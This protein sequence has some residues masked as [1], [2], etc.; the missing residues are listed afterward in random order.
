MPYKIIAKDFK[1]RA[2]ARQWIILNQLGRRNLTQEKFAYMLGKLYEEKK[3]NVIENLKSSK[4]PKPQ[5]EVLGNTAKSIADEYKI[6]HAT[7]ERAAT[8][9]KAV[10]ILAKNLGE[11]VKTKILN[12]DIDVTRQEVVQLAQLNPRGQ[13]TVF[14][15]LVQDNGRTQRVPTEVVLAH[16]THNSGNNEWYT[17]VEYIKA[18]REVMKVIDLDPASNLKANETVKATRYYT[19]EDDG[20]KQEWTGRVWMNPPYATGLITKFCEKMAHHY[21]EGTIEEAII[22]VNNA[23][24]TSWF[25][26][27]IALAGAVV[28]PRNRV[29]FLTLEGKLGAPLQ[30]QALI[31]L[32]ENA[33]EFLKVFRQF[34][35]GALL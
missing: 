2:E 8:F 11:E 32:G 7:V 3:R 35:W 22:L 18:A 6:G 24:E 16:V 15:K 20:L 31:Y 30:G 4:A 14:Q 12:R 21:T 19:A 9:S 10:D 13:E 25:Y 33:E 29:K 26:S 23:T 28:F 5:S 17:P 27:L 34:G 1:D